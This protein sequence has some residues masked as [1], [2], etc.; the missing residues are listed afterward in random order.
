[1]LS[2][3]K[4]DISARQNIVDHTP[5]VEVKHQSPSEDD[6]QEEEDHTWTPSDTMKDTIKSLSFFSDSELTPQNVNK[7]ELIDSYSNFDEWL[8]DEIKTIVNVDKSKIEEKAWGD[9]E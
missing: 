8:R 2:R 5:S 4:K 1:M 7:E 6:P 9:L 3:M